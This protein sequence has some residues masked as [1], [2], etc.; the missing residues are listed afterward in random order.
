M[1]RKLR[2]HEEFCRKFQSK[3]ELTNDSDNKN[4]QTNDS[5][6][7]EWN[8]METVSKTQDVTSDPDPTLI[9]LK[10]NPQVSKA[11]HVQRNYEI[12]HPKENGEIHVIQDNNGPEN[13][14]IIEQVSVNSIKTT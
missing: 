7:M 14:S 5:F 2:R 13:N 4:V 9:D 12:I 1:Q 3:M 10:Q 6:S 8:E 11:I